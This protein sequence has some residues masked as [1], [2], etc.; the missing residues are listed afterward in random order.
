MRP[1]ETPHRRGR[2]VRR[3]L[4]DDCPRLTAERYSSHAPRR[5]GG[6]AG[7][8][9][10]RDTRQLPAGRALVK[11]VPV[12]LTAAVALTGCGIAFGSTSDCF[13]YLDHTYSAAIWDVSLTSGAAETVPSCV[14]VGQFSTTPTRLRRI[15]FTMCTGVYMVMSGSVARDEM[16]HAALISESNTTP[17]CGQPA[18]LQ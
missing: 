7:A 14:S 15:L 1:H 6:I 17:C 13:P 2:R 9:R 18:V 3:R 12:V 4:V 11:K 8:V 16:L 10:W 5:S